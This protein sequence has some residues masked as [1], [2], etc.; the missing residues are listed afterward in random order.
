M[1]KKNILFLIISLGAFSIGNAQIIT[2][3]PST[4]PTSSGR[5]IDEI[6]AQVGDFP[7][8]LS[9]IE[10][11]RI[12][13]LSE[14]EE[15][16]EDAQCFILE[17]LL[18]QKLL[19]NQS[20]IDSI[21]VTDEQV[22]AEM[23][24]R[25]RMIEN[26]IGGR[27]KLEA[28]YGKTYGQIKEEFREVIRDRM[29]SQEEERQITKDIEVSPKEVTKFFKSIPKDSIPY[30]NENIAIQQIVIYPKITQK[31]RNAVIE[32]LNKWREEIVSGERSFAAIATIHSEDLGSAKKGGEIKAT[33][34]M[35]VK[36]FEAAVYA[37]KPGE[38]SN[39]VKT[40][41][42]Y[43]L[44]ELI[45]RKG[46]D[47]IARHILLSP[48][49]GHDELVAAATLMDECRAQLKK[50]E[51]TWDQ[52]VKEYSEDEDTKQNQGNLANP[53]TGNQYWDIAN[54]N[55]IDPQIYGVVNGLETGEISSPAM[56]SDQRTRQQGVRIVRIKDRTEPHK[57]N[58]K[59]DYNFIKQGAENDEKQKVILD[60]VNDKVK[61]T[62][63]HIDG[64]FQNCQFNYSWK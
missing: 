25:L 24:N 42:G 61:N 34:G 5:I 50:N 13:L 1:L 12:Q 44:I 6:V 8:L 41:Y 53:Y 56:Y 11:E 54:I 21:V 55:D 57:A 23:E 52:A 37:L 51:I 20:K 60:W 46:D 4:D 28:F 3:E 58:L 38:I 40:Q 18:Y 36:P 33:R 49:I 48:E 35:M 30:I 10:S 39:V 45:S 59:D 17:K 32:R 63:I 43:H 29:L 2:D 62:Y 14:G 9:D 47:Y 26:Q 15:M 22:N 19:L 7:I 27:D 64:T 31:S 16:D